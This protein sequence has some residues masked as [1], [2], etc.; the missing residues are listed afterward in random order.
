MSNNGIM[1]S[2]PTRGIRV[3]VVCF[4]SYFFVLRSVDRGLQTADAMSNESYKLSANKIPEPGK[5]DAS[6]RFGLS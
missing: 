3:Y 6:D 1:G 2:N 5:L 4:L